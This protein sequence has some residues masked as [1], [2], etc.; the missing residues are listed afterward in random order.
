MLEFTGPYSTVY[1]VLIGQYVS[2][3]NLTYDLINEVLGNIN[4]DVSD[5]AEQMDLTCLH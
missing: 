4:Y 1:G 5:D 2:P 3:L